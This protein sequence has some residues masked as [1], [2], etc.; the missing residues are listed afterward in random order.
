MTIKV[1]RAPEGGAADD[2]AVAAGIAKG[3]KAHILVSAKV[4]VK[5]YGS[6]PR[7]E[8]KSQRIFDRREEG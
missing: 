7:S 6:L 1:E 4:Q 2:E 5:D 3:I 8:R